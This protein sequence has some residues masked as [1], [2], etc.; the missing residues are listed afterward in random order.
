MGFP[1]PCRP[2]SER[3]SWAYVYACR[4]SPPYFPPLSSLSLSHPPSFLLT[5]PTKTHTP[6]THLVAGQLWPSSF[7]LWPPCDL[8]YWLDPNGTRR[9]FGDD[10]ELLPALY[11]AWGGCTEPAWEAD[12]SMATTV[13]YCHSLTAVRPPVNP[14]HPTNPINTTNP[15]NPT[16]PTRSIAR[17]GSKAP[18]SAMP[19]PLRWRRFPT[20][21]L[22]GTSPPTPRSGPRAAGSTTR[23]FLTWD[24]P[25]ERVLTT[26]TE[27]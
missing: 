20:P 19:Y 25:R 10:L 8:D 23:A 14:T 15:T 4:L 18:R 22:D 16:N 26:E 6:H 9:P 2:R 12:E 3:V 21:S 24:P 7:V 11:A 1:Q 13:Y 17:S 27:A 5:P